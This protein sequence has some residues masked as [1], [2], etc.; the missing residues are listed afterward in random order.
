MYAGVNKLNNLC[1]IL[2]NNKMQNE[3]YTKQ[4][5]DVM[6]LIEKW[7]AFNWRVLEIDGHSYL[8]INKAFKKFY[9]EIKSNFNNSQYNKGKISLWRIPQ[10]GILKF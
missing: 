7:R 1:V 9:A 10:F 4:T 5:L 2:D 6:P 8:D 3:T